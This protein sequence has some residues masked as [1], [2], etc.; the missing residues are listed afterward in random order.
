MTANMFGFEKFKFSMRS[1]VCMN[2]FGYWYKEYS[3]E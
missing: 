2:H 1:D 3:M